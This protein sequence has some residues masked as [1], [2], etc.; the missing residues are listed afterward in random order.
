LFDYI[1]K[2]YQQHSFCYAELKGMRTVDGKLERARKEAA[3]IYFEV[4]PQHLPGGI[5]GNNE[6]PVRD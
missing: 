3:V 2:S 1:N 5:E 6:T 4:S